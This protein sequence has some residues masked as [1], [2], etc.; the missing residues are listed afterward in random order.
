MLGPRRLVIATLVVAATL[1]GT[2][3]AGTCPAKTCTRA[4]LK[5]GNTVAATQRRCDDAACPALSR[6]GC[7]DATFLYCSAADMQP[8][9]I[10][11]ISFETS[12]SGGQQNL[13]AEGCLNVCMLNSMWARTKA[14]AFRFRDTYHS[15][16][17]SILRHACGRHGPD[18]W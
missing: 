16:C 9:V 6:C 2:A 8:Y 1:A 11:A 3:I 4:V 17:R 14:W 18:R 10:A 12:Y 5:V 15:V 13:K 7:P